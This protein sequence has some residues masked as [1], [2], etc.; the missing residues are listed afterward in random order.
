M[1]YVYIIFSFKNTINSKTLVRNRCN[2]FSILPILK[3]D[4]T[5]TNILVKYQKGVIIFNIDNIEN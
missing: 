3:T 1:F 4:Y 5:N 2:R